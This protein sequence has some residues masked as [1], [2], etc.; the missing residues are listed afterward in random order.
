M[1]EDDGH[2]KTAVTPVT[3]TSDAPPVKGFTLKE[4]AEHVGVSISTMRRRRPDLLRFGAAVTEDGI[5]S[6]PITTLEAAGLIETTRPN[7]S[8]KPQEEPV[9]APG[10]ALQTPQESPE[11]EAL[12]DALERIREL[13]LELL[14]ERHRAELAEVR[15]AAAEQRATAAEILAADRAETLKVERRMLMPGPSAYV[16]A[17][18]Q[19]EP[20]APSSAPAHDAHQA[21]PQEPP[22]HAEPRPSWW[23]RTFG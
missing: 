9:E 14:E 4:A 19:P 2:Q 22:G 3:A 7:E 20:P 12:A 21:P 6:I 1:S 11:G 15:L 17:A 10:T 18:P 5:W 16:Q 8:E 23:R 13:E